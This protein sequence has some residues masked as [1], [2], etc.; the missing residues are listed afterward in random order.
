MMFSIYAHGV[1]LA[2]LWRS[3]CHWRNTSKALFS[4]YGMLSML[5]QCLWGWVVWSLDDT[6]RSLTELEK[7]PILE[8]SGVYFCCKSLYMPYFISC[9]W[10]VCGLQ[11]YW[12]L[13]VCLLLCLLICSLQTPGTV[14]W[15]P[16]I[17]PLLVVLG[18]L[19]G[20]CLLA[21]LAWSTGIIKS[22]VV[23]LQCTFWLSYACILCVLYEMWCIRMRA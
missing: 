13:I 1:L 3:P 15:Y 19:L 10:H 22:A 17:L 12:Y 21:C 8:V 23:D 18:F 7:S 16:A 20:C 14:S 11:T 5:Y 2:G 4:P 9:V 6:G